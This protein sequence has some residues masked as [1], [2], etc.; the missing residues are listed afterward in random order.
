[1]EKQIVELGQG[2]RSGTL[3]RGL[4]NLLLIPAWFT[5]FKKIRSICHQLRGIKMGKNVEIG[6]MVILDNRRPEL[7]T[8][9]D[10]VIITAMSIILT[11]DMSIKNT[12]GKEII[13]KV[14]IGK[15][16]FI[17]MN[18]TILPG[19]TI[20]NYCIIGAG[21]VVSKDTED[22]SVYIGNA[23]IRLR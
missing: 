19:V 5:P 20:G 1:M 10:D 17:G 6:Y 23:A 7:I 22:Y 8:I 14:T 4:K 16:A 9:G 21:T 2:M 12:K 3:K 11:H 18:S 15:G 13:G